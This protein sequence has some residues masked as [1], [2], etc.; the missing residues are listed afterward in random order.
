MSMIEQELVQACDFKP[1]KKYKQRQDYLAAIV[2]A[3]A[4]LPDADFEKISDP[5][6][7]WANAAAR[8]LRTKTTLPDFPDLEAEAG[9]EELPALEPTVENTPYPEPEKP[10]KLRRK[11]TGEIDRY[12]VSVGSR[13]NQA[14]LLFERGATMKE[15][16]EVTGDSKYNLLKKLASE[17]H[18]IER[19]GPVF[20]L[21]HK[22]G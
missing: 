11:L 21:I 12:G 3:I 19:D 17:G 14:I 5:A 9:S 6:S 1:A 7:D 18:T 15:V 13:S 4:A 20:R 16:K 2:V 8:A 10:K 22:D